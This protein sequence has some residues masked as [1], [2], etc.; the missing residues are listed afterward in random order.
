MDKYVVSDSTIPCIDLEGSPHWPVAVYTKYT[1]NF[2][3]GIR[4]TQDL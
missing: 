3:C 1:S 2:P 4:L